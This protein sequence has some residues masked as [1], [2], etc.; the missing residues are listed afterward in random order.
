M[1]SDF[2]YQIDEDSS[3]YPVLRLRGDLT[4]RHAQEFREA[5]T[6]L[7]V[8]GHVVL[9]FENLRFIDSSGLS[10]LLLL[11][12][13]EPEAVIYLAATSAPI[14]SLVEKMQL[15]HIFALP[16]TVAEARIEME[17]CLATPQTVA[18]S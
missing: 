12:K 11:R 1:R 4:A 6:P 9:D 3:Q 2:S 13:R 18:A 14:R 5:A 7:L 10:A 8:H 16:A 15:H 17:R